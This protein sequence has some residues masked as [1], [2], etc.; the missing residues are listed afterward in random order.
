MG[1][2]IGL[3]VS[4]RGRPKMSDSG[5]T[6]GAVRP[7]VIPIAAANWPAAAT[8]VSNAAATATN[9]GPI[10]IITVR[11]R[12]TAAERKATSRIRDT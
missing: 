2:F 3:D 5:P 4:L 12:N 11:T 6:R 9:R 8:E 1:V 10:I 7:Q